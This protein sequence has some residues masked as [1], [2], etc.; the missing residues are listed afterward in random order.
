MV[1]GF[2]YN[3][4]LFEEHHPTT[5]SDKVWFDERLDPYILH[6]RVDIGDK[7]VLLR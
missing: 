5:R 2:T 6:E 3:K 1:G 4:K 7:L